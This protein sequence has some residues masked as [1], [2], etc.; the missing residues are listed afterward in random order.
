MLGAIQRSLL[1]WMQWV[2]NPDIIAKFNQEELVEIDKVLANFV[3]SFIEY[4]IKLTTEGLQKGL[5]IKQ[6]ARRTPS[7]RS[8]FV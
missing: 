5:V 1:G 6:R 2:N 3:K 4:D 8:Y 7:R